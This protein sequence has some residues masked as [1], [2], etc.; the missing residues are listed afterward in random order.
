LT[1]GP[2]LAEKAEPKEPMAYL[3]LTQGPPA[4]AASAARAG[5]PEQSVRWERTER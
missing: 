4:T 2:A 3:E 5:L 1:T